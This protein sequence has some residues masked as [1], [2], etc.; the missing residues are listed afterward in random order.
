MSEDIQA[1]DIAAVGRLEALRYC[2]MGLE[3]EA[4]LAVAL[5]AVAAVVFEHTRSVPASQK[6]LP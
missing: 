2:D 4:Y 3:L 5:L 6:S 1:V